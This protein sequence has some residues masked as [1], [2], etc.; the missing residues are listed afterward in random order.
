MKEC[1]RIGTMVSRIDE[2]IIINALIRINEGKKRIRE[3][4]TTIKK[5]KNKNIVK[6]IE[7]CEKDERGFSLDG[8]MLDSLLSELLDLIRKC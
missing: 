1:V 5:T 8:R 4:S 3:R 2:L 7:I 6:E